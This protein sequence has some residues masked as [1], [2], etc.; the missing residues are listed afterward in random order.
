M[1][2]IE[3]NKVSQTERERGGFQLYIK[4][5]VEVSVENSWYIGLQVQD[6]GNMTL[7]SAN[8]GIGVIIE[9]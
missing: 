1:I 8:N 9:H 6:P 7:I 5:C 3:E 4:G 2:G